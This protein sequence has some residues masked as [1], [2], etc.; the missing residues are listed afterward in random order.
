MRAMLD[1]MRLGPG[2][3]FVNLSVFEP[4]DE[5]SINANTI[6]YDLLAR[7]YPFKI[8]KRLDYIDPVVFYHPAEWRFQSSSDHNDA[9]A[10]G[11]VATG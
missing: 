1:P 5:G 8:Y 3:Y 4:S 2:D 11:I 10:D 9:F 7:F 6:R